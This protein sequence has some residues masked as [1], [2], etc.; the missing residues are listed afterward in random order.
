MQLNLISIKINNDLL[1]FII[2]CKQLNISITNRMKHL[3]NRKQNRMEY[4]Y[5]KYMQILEIHKCD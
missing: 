3:S 5:E 1:R 2:D 4:F